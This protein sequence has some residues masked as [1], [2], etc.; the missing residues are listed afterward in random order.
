MPQDAFFSHDTAALLWGMPLPW[1]FESSSKLHVA[2]PNPARAPHAQGIAGHKLMVDDADIV[3]RSD[4]LRLTSPNR[5]WLDLGTR[6]SLVHLVAAGDFALH[7]RHPLTTAADLARELVRRKNRRGLALLHTAVALLND[8]SESAPESILRV[9]IV[10]AG[11]PE[12]TVNRIVTDRFGEF[13]A[14]TDLVIAELGLVI[15]YMGD[16]HRTTKGQWRA[17]MTRR[18]K[19]EAEGWRVLELNADDLCDP[20]ELVAR[21]LRFAA[22]SRR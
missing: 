10:L 4:G 3:T 16:Y 14:R 11:L 2:V 1:Q 18:S 20:E 6:L 5:T 15:E 12:P 19:L 13:V 7:W 9:L 22:T 8:R 21:I 17:D